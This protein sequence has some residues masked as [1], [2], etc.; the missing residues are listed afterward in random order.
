VGSVVLGG[1][2]T[3]LVVALWIRLFPQL[4]RRDKLVPERLT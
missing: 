1:A 2:G 4:A 3:L